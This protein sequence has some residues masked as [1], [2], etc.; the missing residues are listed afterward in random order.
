MPYGPTFRLT[1]LNLTIK[2]IVLSLYRNP[3]QCPRGE[4]RLTRSE[5]DYDLIHCSRG[6]RNYDAVECPKGSRNC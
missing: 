4:P 5:G 6:Y 1:V 2:I 3:R